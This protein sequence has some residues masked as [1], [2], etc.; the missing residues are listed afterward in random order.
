M[1]N[2]KTEPNQP[3]F[4]CASDT[5][6]QEGLTKREYFAAMAMQ[7][8]LTRTPK[9]DGHETDLGV[10]ESERI[11]AESVIVADKLIRFLNAGNNE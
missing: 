10:L 9:R 7:G 8:L 3:A 5:G 6:H 2:N 4:A 11:A 1:S